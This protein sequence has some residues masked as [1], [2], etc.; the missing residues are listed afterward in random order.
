MRILGECKGEPTASAIRSG[1][2]LTAFYA[3]LGQLIVG[4]GRLS[5]LPLLLLA[6]PKTARFDGFVRELLNNRLLIE[7][8]LEVILVDREGSVE[9]SSLE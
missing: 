7:W 3:A 4:A 6:F 8:N 1:L 9:L 2:D 5:P